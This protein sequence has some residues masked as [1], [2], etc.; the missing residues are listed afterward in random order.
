M[1]GDDDPEE[2][3]S[4]LVLTSP[5]GLFVDLRILADCSSGGGP[6]N[7]SERHFSTVDWAFAG[8]SLRQPKRP[9]GVTAAS[10]THWVDSRTVNALSVHD[11]GLCQPLPNGDELETGEMLDPKGVMRPYK[12]IWHDEP[13]SPSRAAVFVCS[14]NAS[15]L[16]SASTEDMATIPP[17]EVCGMMIRVG[18]WSQG[19]L[20]D[21]QA[22]ADEG[23][24]AFTAERWALRA[25]GVWQCTFRTGVRKLPLNKVNGASTSVTSG[26][27]SFSERGLYWKCVELYEDEAA[28]KE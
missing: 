3:T 10:W 27:L 4:T 2:K 5:S 12:E 17:R 6:G 22:G 1:Q 13:V 18:S 8:R 9:D 26:E 25:D 20:R 23:K 16:D 14:R 19:V 21:L 11:A 15:A 28:A 24:E 7:T